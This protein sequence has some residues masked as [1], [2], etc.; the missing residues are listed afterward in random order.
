M[1]TLDSG[2]TPNP[3]VSSSNGSGV[4]AGSSLNVR[5]GELGVS[6]SG[7]RNNGE[8]ISGEEAENRVVGREK[9]DK[10]VSFGGGKDGVS[11]FGGE[12]LGGNRVEEIGVLEVESE[13]LAGKN[14]GE[15]AEGQVLARER[16]RIQEITGGEA[17]LGLVNEKQNAASNATN[18]HIPLMDIGEKLVSSKAVSTSVHGEHVGDKDS[19]L[20]RGALS[21]GKPSV[22]V[23][24]HELSVAGIEGVAQEEQEGEQID[25]QKSRFKVGDFVWGKVKGHSWWPGQIYDHSDA[26]EYAAKHSRRNCF[27]VVYFANKMFGWCYPSQLRSFHEGFQLLWRQ[28]CSKSFL[29]AMEAALNE[30]G[31][32]VKLEMICSCVP[33]EARAT[34]V[35]PVTVNAG[36][37]EGVSSP[38][39]RIGELS[40][41]EFDPA[42]FLSRLRGLAR[43]VSEIDTLELTVFIGRIS[44]FRWVRG[45]GRLPMPK[46]IS[47]VSGAVDSAEEQ[48]SD[49]NKFDDQRGHTQEPDEEGGVSS[50]M[51]T[52]VG[53]S[54]R[55]TSRRG[56]HNMGDKYQRKKRSMAE[57]LQG[58]M[59]IELESNTTNV[60]EEGKVTDKLHLSSKKHT[61]IEHAGSPST[62]MDNEDENDNDDARDG[63]SAPSLRQRKSKHFA[64]SSMPEVISTSTSKDDDVGQGGAILTSPRIRK[65]SK[66]LSPPYTMLGG[67]AGMLSPK[68]VKAGTSKA[69]RASRV[70]DS[71][72]GKDVETETPK[73]TDD[74][75]N[76]EAGQLIVSPLIQRCS[77]EISQKKVALSV[78][79]EQKA[80]GSPSPQTPEFD[81]SADEMLS[82]L[83]S[84]ALD[85]LYLKGNRSSNAVKGFFTKYRSA[86]Y[87]FDISKCVADV[88]STERKL[89]QAEHDSLEK[90]SRVADASEDKFAP[91]DRNRIS[92]SAVPTSVGKDSN[93]AVQSVA[94]SGSG[95]GKR[96]PQSNKCFSLGKDSQADQSVPKSGSDVI[97][98][99]SFPRTPFSLGN[100]SGFDVIEGNSFP[101]TP[102]SLG[103]D[104]NGAYQSVPKSVSSGR[105]RK[106]LSNIHVSPGKDS[107]AADQSHGKI[108]QK[109]KRRKEK[110]SSTKTNSKSG[111]PMSEKRGPVEWVAGNSGVEVN[112]KEADGDNPVAL[113]LTFTPGF[114]LPSKEDFIR[115]FS[116]FGG[117]IE[118]E[119][120]VSKESG[121]A[122]VVFTRSSDAEAFN[123]SDK[124][125]AFGPHIVSCQ[126][127][128]L[129]RVPEGFEMNSSFHLPPTALAG[130]VTP[131]PSSKAV[132][133]PPLHVIR[134]NLEIMM[135]MLSESSE[136]E[137]SV[138]KLSPEVQANLTGEIKGLLKKISLS[139]SLPRRTRRFSRLP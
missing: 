113:F 83:L 112:Q 37:K 95:G 61:K 10:S 132:N 118:S 53:K 9:G 129:S 135:S 76:G 30:L 15:V 12:V 89:P 102:F 68:D 90:D 78:H 138:E 4:S 24:G 7:I 63:K 34:L 14:G 110:G 86:S 107:S 42:N 126:M 48:I 100:G 32:C 62:M 70:M 85:P 101:R 109:T 69:P 59:D 84:A 97:E 27:L 1:E 133:G 123:N 130:I 19:L 57:L 18:A 41:A 28:S 52:S 72:N 36:L 94:K 77:V 22:G 64:F 43:V 6:V 55:N 5:A 29:S 87:S 49:N 71:L 104:S 121:S 67:L 26:S 16:E 115:I 20:E 58:D 131:P 99:N 139:T 117:L 50:P 13:V 111:W 124:N 23:Q 122:R 31:R 33:V 38:Q 35:R 119:T 45:Y 105:K 136:K 98:G 8:R 120:V 73:S 60:T 47:K 39:G 134:Q 51:D 2:Q 114:P 137:T 91:G 56:S 46:E 54:G 106:T 81:A 74:S 82:E 21:V 108:G 93:Q 79:G 65:K 25:A 88:G 128:S 40:I 3:N 92:V 11:L 66:Y 125:T 127:Q 96:K 80:P 116:K 44:A 103:N 75:E 17:S